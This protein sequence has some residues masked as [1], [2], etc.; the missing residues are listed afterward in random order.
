MVKQIQSH[1]EKIKEKHGT[2]ILDQYAPRKPLEEASHDCPQ[3]ARFVIHA[4][5]DVNHTPISND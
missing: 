5:S 1:G 3:L 2:R 4:E